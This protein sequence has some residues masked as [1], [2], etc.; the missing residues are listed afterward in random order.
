MV[1]ELLPHLFLVVV[2]SVD[3]EGCTALI[4]ACRENSEEIARILLELGTKQVQAQHEHENEK[5]SDLPA[6]SPPAADGAGGSEAKSAAGSKESKEGKTP[7]S[8]PSTQQAQPSPRTKGRFAHFGAGGIDIN[9]QDRQGLIPCLAPGTCFHPAL[10]SS[11]STTSSSHRCSFPSSPPPLADLSSA[12]FLS[13]LYLSDVFLPPL[14]LSFF[15]TRPSFCRF[16]PVLLFLSLSICLTVY[17]SIHLSGWSALH[18]AAAKGNASLVRLLLE[19]GAD[20]GL[21]SNNALL[22]LDCVQCLDNGFPEV[23]LGG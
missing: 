14:R 6:S 18:W 1:F 11:S 13:S 19:K 7:E 17:L 22:P 15:V 23:G 5:K 9:F 8:R 10:S 16:L 12:F 20:A 21:L 3:E 2:V 4:I